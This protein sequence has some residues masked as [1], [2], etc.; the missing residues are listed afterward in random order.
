VALMCA[1]RFNGVPR[2]T[3]FLPTPAEIIA[4]CERKVRPMY[5]DA[6][7]E[8]RVAKQ[9]AERERW[10]NPD[11]ADEETVRRKEIANAWLNRDDERAA[12]LSRERPRASLTAEDRQALLDDAR[13]VASEINRGGIK[14]SAEAQA[15]LRE[16]DARR[17]M[18]EASDQ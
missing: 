4:Y 13:A 16:Q 5:E 6:E 9:L 18:D 10:L 11:R 12:E 8:D 2:E 15:L 7:R 17:A 14:L 3:K 1:D